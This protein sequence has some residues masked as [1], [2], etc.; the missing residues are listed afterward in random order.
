MRV[1]LD[2]S[3]RYRPV[4]ADASRFQQVVWNLLGNAIKFSVQGGL[5][6]VRL[7]EDETGLRMRVTDSGQGIGADFLPFVF[8]RFAQSDEPGSRQRGGLGLGLAIVKHIVDA[9]GGTIVVHSDGPGSGTMFE[10]WLP[11]DRA[12]AGAD[13]GG[14]P[15]A[16]GSPLPGEDSILSGITVLVV[17]DDEDVLEAL[18]IV[19]SDRGARVL[20]AAGVD[21]A[22]RLIDAEP[23]DILVSDIGMPAKDGYDLI[24]AVR[25]REAELSASG[26]G[27]AHLPAIAHTSF[28]RE[29]DVEQGL[30]AGFDAHCAKP[31]R[32]LPLLRAMRHLLGR[33]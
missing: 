21:E 26:G 5:I 22:L 16:A 9:H 6:T 10:V 19:L 13:F 28:S 11:V 4:R 18:G 23:L 29:K 15:H 24:R 8:E 2:A 12:P 17:D 30:A 14:S 20:T 31:L 33:D 7:V 25:A 32:P 27:R 1:E 3:E